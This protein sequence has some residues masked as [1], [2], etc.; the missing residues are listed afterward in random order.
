MREIWLTLPIP[1]ST[2]TVNVH[3]GSEKIYQKSSTSLSSALP[4]IGSL[5]SIVIIVAVSQNSS[6]SSAQYLLVFC[7]SWAWRCWATWR[8]SFLPPTQCWRVNRNGIIEGT[9]WEKCRAS[10]ASEKERKSLTDV[11]TSGNHWRGYNSIE[12][13][14]QG[15]FEVK[16][17]LPP[18]TK[19]HPS[20]WYPHLSSWRVLCVTRTRRTE[21]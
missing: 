17:L 1:P 12:H 7:H 9:A 20:I 5:K 21:L 10:E 14:R 19:L 16:E 15:S 8:L 18:T 6:P 4:L 11:K 2:S 13:L 3:H